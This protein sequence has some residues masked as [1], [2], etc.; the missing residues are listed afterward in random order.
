[1]IRSKMGENGKKY[2]FTN[3]SLERMGQEFL[4]VYNTVLGSVKSRIDN[5]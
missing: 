1:L 3:H 4:E 2:V 5:Y